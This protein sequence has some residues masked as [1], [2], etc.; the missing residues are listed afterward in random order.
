MGPAG[1]VGL[2]LAMPTDVGL[3]VGVGP[4]VGVAVQA[5]AAIRALTTRPH[6]D[7]GC[8]RADIAAAY[9]D[10]ASRTCAGV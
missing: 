5:A 2:A 6:A 4:G 9:D 3:G 10:R 7:H 8:G 1:S